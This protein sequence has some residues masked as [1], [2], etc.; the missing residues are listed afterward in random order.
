MLTGDYDQAVVSYREGL[1]HLRRPDMHADVPPLGDSARDIFKA[2]QLNL[3]HAQLKREDFQAAARAAD[4][5]LT[6]DPQ[7]VKA[8]FRRGMAMG[9]LGMFH[10]ALWDLTRARRQEPNDRLILRTLHMT[11]RV[12]LRVRVSSSSERCT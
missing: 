8:L 11:V 2:L 12:R 4:A 6:V 10:E 9:R 5:A 1:D 3:S 7:N